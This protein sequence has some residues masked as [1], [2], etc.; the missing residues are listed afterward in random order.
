[1]TEWP[2]LKVPS[3]VS[4]GLQNAIGWAKEAASSPAG[5]SWSKDRLWQVPR[6]RAKLR[7]LLN[8]GCFLASYISCKSFYILLKTFQFK[9]FEF[10]IPFRIWAGWDD[11][12]S[13]H[14]IIPLPFFS[15]K[16][17]NTCS[18]WLYLHWLCES[19]IFGMVKFWNVLS[20]LWFQFLGA[21][22]V[23]WFLDSGVFV[24]HPLFFARFF[25]LFFSILESRWMISSF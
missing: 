14:Y 18:I 19:N 23:S 25:P 24:F 4:G 8:K 15:L 22:N 16:S 12:M 10:I 20:M 11:I 5:E 2:L 6:T 7:Y 13:G 1:M 17:I 9:S 21:E 3:Q